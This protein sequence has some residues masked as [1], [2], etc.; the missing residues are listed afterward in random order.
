[1]KNKLDIV[2]SKKLSPQTVTEIDNSVDDFIERHKNN[3]QEI[4]QLVF[5]SMIALTTGNKIAKEKTAQG[6]FKRLGRNITGENNQAQNNINQDIIAVQFAAQKTLQK[7][8]EQNI[9]SFEL[10]AA[11]NNKLNEAIT[12]TNAEI[13]NVHKIMQQFFI[14]TKRKL[15][16]HEERIAKLERNV[17]LLDWVTTI[18]TFTLDGVKYEKLDDTTRIVCIVRDFLTIVGNNRQAGDLKYL[19][20]AL[21]TLKLGEKFQINISNF[22]R[23][24]G[25]DAK[26]YNL[27]L[28]ADSRLDEFATES[29]PIIWSLHELKKFD[30]RK[31]LPLQTDIANDDTSKTTAYDLA[32]NFIYDFNQVSYAKNFYEKKTRARELFFSCKIEEALPLLQELAEEYDVQSRYILALIYMGI[33]IEKNLDY[34]KEILETNIAAGDICSMFLAKRLRKVK[35]NIAGYYLYY[36]KDIADSGDVFAQYELARYYWDNENFQVALEY[37]E[38]AA[39]QDFFLAIYSLGWRYYF[40]KFVKEDNIKARQYFERGAKIGY[41]ESMLKLGDIYWNGYGITVDKQKAVELY[42]NAYALHAYDANSVNHIGDFYSN[43]DANCNYAEALKWWKIGEEKNYFFC[44]SNLG[45]A[46][47]FGKGVTIDYKKAVEYYEKSIAAGLKN[48]YPEEHIGTIYY[49]GDYGISKDYKKAVEYYEK[50][51][52][53]GSKSNYL[54]ERIGDIYF[55]GGNGVSQDYEKAVE[56]YKKAYERGIVS[57]KIILN[58]AEC[59]HTFYLEDLKEIKKNSELIVIFSL[60]SSLGVNQNI[61][62]ALKWL[63]IGEEKNYPE[64]IAYLGKYYRYGEGVLKNSLKAVEYF[65]L[66]IVKGSVS[67]F[68]ERNIAEMIIKGECVEDKILKISRAPQFILNPLVWAGTSYIH[69]RAMKKRAKEWYQESAAKGDEEAKKWLKENE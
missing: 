17:K 21:D 4:N 42:K 53:L 50:A 9:L 56:Y 5:E 10:I 60:G 29:E 48:A 43:E 14:E 18:K 26:L 27:L 12:D 58:L 3:R 62:E 37:F 11:V 34:S 32:L 47:Q 2:D 59:Y 6:F 57:E 52:S 38:K 67:G 54:E 44:I 25:E 63:R 61:N 33:N 28:G 68:P 46:Y 39:S 13:N 35:E 36:I 69:E 7:L 30:G 65:K 20:T 1:M 40:G 23:Q 16:D 64:C 55:T 22:I 24:V 8:A 31:N 19:E 66:A 49:N 45:W 41:G 15:V 51:I